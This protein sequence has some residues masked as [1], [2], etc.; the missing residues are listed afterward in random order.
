MGTWTSTP[1]VR[2]STTSMSTHVSYN[3][4][5]VAMTKGYLVLDRAEIAVG[6]AHSNLLDRA[7]V[8]VDPVVEDP[9]ICVITAIGLVPN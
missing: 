8:G 9:K 7:K 3:G 4:K 6:L 1:R 2:V 5:E